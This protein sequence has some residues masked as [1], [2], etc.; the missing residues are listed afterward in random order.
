MLK[1]KKIIALLMMA[2]MFAQSCSRGVAPTAGNFNYVDAPLDSGGVTTSLCQSEGDQDTDGDGVC[3]SDEVALGTDPN[4]TDSD[5]DGI[6]DCDDN[7]TKCT[8]FKFIGVSLLSMAGVA[9]VAA[10]VVAVKNKANMGKWFFSNPSAAEPGIY[11]NPTQAGSVKINPNS[12]SQD[13]FYKDGDNITHNISKNDLIIENATVDVAIG[14]GSAIAMGQEVIS[15]FHGAALGTIAGGDDATNATDLK[16]S[17]YF[18]NN[19]LKHGQKIQ[20]YMTKE[21]FFQFCETKTGIFYGVQVK[22]NTNTFYTRGASTKAFSTIVQS[23]SVAPGYDSGV[24]TE[25]RF[26]AIPNDFDANAAN[27][28]SHNYAGLNAFLNANG[29]STKNSTSTLAYY[30]HLPGQNDPSYSTVYYALTNEAG[31]GQTILPEANSRDT[32]VNKLINVLEASKTQG[33]SKLRT[34]VIQDEP[35]DTGTEALME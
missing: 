24:T 18:K 31:T 19:Y 14:N 35:V 2:A 34:N 7:V 28:S 22:E 5:G 30:K 33:Q 9:T 4:A 12:K 17:S 16:V 27:Y 32:F 29:N 20:R 11:L 25:Y 1:S 15:C 26:V 13:Y 23:Q 3:D 21:E 6:D 10:G 8:W